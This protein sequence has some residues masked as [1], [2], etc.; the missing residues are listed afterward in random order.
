MPRTATTTSSA[1]ISREFA[2]QNTEQAMRAATYGL[3]FMREITE[4]NINQAKVL[5]QGLLTITKKV[6]VEIDQQSSEFFH[7]SMSLA[8]ETFLN[9]FDF[10]Q[11]VVR[12]REP[13]ELAQL[14]NEFVTR[15]T[16]TVVDQAKELGESM[17]QHANEGAKTTS[18]EVT[19][20]SRRRS[21]AA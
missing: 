6:V 3:N 4:Q 5:L 2:E 1:A 18:Y 9:A 10:A 14:Q 20:L 21:E 17:M 8:E 15:Q 16:Q 19:E 11:K 7:R 12:A 13:Q